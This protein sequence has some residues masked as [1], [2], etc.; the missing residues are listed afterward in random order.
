MPSDLP[1]TLPPPSSQRG[2]PPVSGEET[3]YNQA[4]LANRATSAPGGLRLP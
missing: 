3:R 1:P 4:A 2:P